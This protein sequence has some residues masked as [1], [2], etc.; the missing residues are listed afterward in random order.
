MIFENLTDYTLIISVDGREDVTVLPGSCE[1][2]FIDNESILS[3]EEYDA[4]SNM[5]VGH[6]EPDFAEE[7]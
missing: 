6:E 4:E 7:G 1:A 3:V 5:A 2:V